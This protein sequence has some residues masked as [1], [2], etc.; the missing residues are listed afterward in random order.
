MNLNR[1]I[2][3]NE[4]KDFTCIEILEEDNLIIN[5]IFEIDENC[6]NIDYNLK[7]L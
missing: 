6:Y 5:N 3:T 1:K 7:K 2:W 4:E